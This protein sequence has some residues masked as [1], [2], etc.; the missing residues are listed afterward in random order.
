[1][2]HDIAAWTLASEQF[3]RYINHDRNLSAAQLAVIA[4]Q[5][6]SGQNTL[7][8]PDAIERTRDEATARIIDAERKALLVRKTRERMQLSATIRGRLEAEDLAAKASGRAP[9]W[10]PMLDTELG[11]RMRS[12]RPDLMTEHGVDGPTVEAEAMA[13]VARGE[14]GYMLAHINVT[15]PAFAGVVQSAPVASS[16]DLGPN[17]RAPSGG[18]ANGVAE[19]ITAAR[20]DGAVRAL[21]RLEADAV[22]AEGVTRALAA[23]AATDDVAH[24]AIRAKHGQGGG[25]RVVE[26]TAAIRAS[27]PDLSADVARGFARR[28][29][30]VGL[31]R[32]GDLEKRDRLIARTAH[33]LGL[34]RGAVRATATH[35]AVRSDSAVKVGAAAAAVFDRYLAEIERGR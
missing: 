20:A 30:S 2:P 8:R 21:R 25:D 35:V 11:S 29:A 28:V 26:M 1:M 16:P 9:P 31:D 3:A 14:F 5:M 12:Q 17:P 6:R 34:T 18:R 27:F 19:T 33:E 7:I 13:N 4:A 24:N 10:G 23:I 15:S 22:R 32:I